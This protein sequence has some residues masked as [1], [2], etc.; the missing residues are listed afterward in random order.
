MDDHFVINLRIADTRY[1]I[2]IKRADEELFRRA[3]AEIDY[4]LS[5]YKDYFKSDD[6]HSEQD[7]HYIIMT[8]LQAVAESEAKEMRADFFERGI[9]KLIVDID[10]YLKDS[11]I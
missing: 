3:A 2:R 6:P 8:A 1:P 9:E 11:S 5:Q 4:K 7:T 10:S